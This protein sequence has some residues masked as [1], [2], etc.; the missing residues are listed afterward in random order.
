LR[1]AVSDDNPDVFFAP[2]YTAP[3]GLRVPLAL[4]IHDVSFAAHPEWFRPR[5]GL[6]RRWLTRRSAHRAA[7]VF[8][9]SEFSRTEIERHFRVPASRIVVISPGVTDRAGAA[10]ATAPSEPYVLYVGT[11]FNRRRLPDL[12]E[13]FAIA[14]RD[15]DHVRLVI[16]GVD[17]TWPAQDLSAIAAQHGVHKRVELRR[18]APD[19]QLTGLYAGAS[20]FA[21]LSEYEGFGL[22]PLE[23][24]SAGVPAIVLDTP[25][26]REIYGDAAIL[27]A[28]GDIGGTAAAIRRLLLDPSSAAPLRAAATRILA[29][30][31]WDA[32]ADATLTQLLRIVRR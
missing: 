14:T 27:V 12:I 9:D 8:T 32:A 17:R 5:E 29:R 20:G 22:T 6:R 25:V 1:R 16:V 7:V 21:F 23:A 19:S 18:Y 10:P 15:L 28:R 3:L 24:M 13:S 4:T 2:A 31:S 30:Y 26:A 11:L